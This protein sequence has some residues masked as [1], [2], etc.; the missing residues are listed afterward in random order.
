MDKEKIANWINDSKHREAMKWFENLKEYISTLEQRNKDLLDIVRDPEGEVARCRQEVRE[1]QFKL[2][3]QNAYSVTS[4]ERRTGH[5]WLVD[6]DEQCHENSR[7][8][9][10]WEISP[11]PLGIAV[12]IVCDVCGAKYCVRME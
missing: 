8:E 11:H 9:Y 4:E 6:H 5:S 1:L 2:R 10:H 7:C 3:L 12:E